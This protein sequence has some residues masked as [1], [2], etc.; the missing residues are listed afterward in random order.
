MKFFFQPKKID[1]NEHKEKTEENFKIVYDSND[2]INSGEGVEGYASLFRSRYEKSLR[3]LS[4]RQD[5]KR[6][7]KI[8]IIKQL[9]NQSNINYKSLSKEVANNPLVIGRL[10]NG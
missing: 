4:L 7:K 3:I 5:S 2:K 8:E 6:V 9:F 10:G 1:L